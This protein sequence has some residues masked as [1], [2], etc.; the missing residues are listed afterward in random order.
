MK[1]VYGIYNNKCKVEVLAKDDSFGIAK[2]Q[3]IGTSAVTIDNPENNVRYISVSA[4]Y[5]TVNNLSQNFDGYF[6]IVIRRTYKR[7]KYSEHIKFNG[8]AIKFVNDDTVS[9]N[10][11]VLTYKIHN[12]G[13]NIVCECSGYAE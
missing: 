10:I 13:L 11:D 12:D 5:V 7:S 6:E 9:S 8:V 2:E 4:Q 1:K 3:I